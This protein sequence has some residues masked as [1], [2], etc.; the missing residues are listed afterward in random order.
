MN[1]FAT[2][3]SARR[4]RRQHGMAMVLVLFVI[5]VLSL[6]G[7]A[8]TRSAQTELQMGDQEM[9]GRK[10]LSAAEAGINHA[11]SLI[12]ANLTGRP[13]VPTACSTCWGF[14]SELSGGGTG[15]ALTSIGSTATLNGVTYRFRAFGGG[16]QDGYYVQAADNYD[17]QTGANNTSFDRDDR[18]YLVSHGRVGNAE[19]VVTALLTGNSLFGGSAIL[20]RSSITLSGGSTTD[21]F[22]SRDGA[23][24]AATALADGNVRANGSIN[25]SGGSTVINGNATATGSVTG[26]GGSHVNGTTTNGAPTLSFP[27]VPACGPPYS[28]SS[29]IT[30]GTY[31]SSTGAWTVSGGGTG[32]LATGTYCFSTITF[33]GGST[34]S[35]SSPVNVYTTGQ[36]DLSGGTV[37]NST[38][39]AASFKLFMSY[40]STSQG[41]KVSGGSQSYMAVYAPDCVVNFSGGLTDFYGSVV[42]YSVTATGGTRIHYDQT[43]GGVLGTGVQLSGWHEV[44]N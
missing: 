24:S 29:G 8:G 16:S 40:S 21:S 18:I 11:Y 15:G 34:L 2:K 13:G 32:S 37:A 27:S 23:Y 28:G 36:V 6:L 14:D 19:R 22:D 20:A 41:I 44:R 10:A 1:H 5:A 7:I 35:I 30:G 43:V 26:S 38:L 3:V 39:S 12:S 17:E 31:N 4:P 33:N 9:L 25:M 42:G